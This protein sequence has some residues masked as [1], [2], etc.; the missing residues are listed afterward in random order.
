[1]TDKL[2]LLYVEDD[3]V[4]RENFKQIFEVYFDKVLVSDNGNDALEIYNQNHIDVAILD[5]SIPGMN[6]LSLASKIR[7]KD[8]DITLFIISAHSDQEKLLQAVNLRLFGYLVKPVTHKK[9]DESLQKIIKSVLPKTLVEL[10]ENFFWSTLSYQLLYKNETIKL[11]KNES[12][13]VHFLINNK[14]IYFTA[15]DIQNNLFNTNESTDH[16]CNN[17]VQILSRFKKKIL[18]YYSADNFFIENCYGSG[19]RI[20]TA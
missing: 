1:M 3:E 11:T 9:I 16:H 2:T 14:N 15:C 20:T 10:S 17:V 5:I 6:G 7:E 12:K 13:I 18:K 4:V 19:Y 8:D